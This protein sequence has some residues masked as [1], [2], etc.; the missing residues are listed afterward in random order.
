MWQ[1]WLCIANTANAATKPHGDSSF[2][3]FKTDWI[4]NCLS[5][6]QFFNLALV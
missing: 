3:L 6:A 2:V 1:A 4:A 5:K